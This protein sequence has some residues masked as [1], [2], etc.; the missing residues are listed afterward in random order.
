MLVAGASVIAILGTL[1]KQASVGTASDSLLLSMGTGPL[2]ATEPD[3]VVV[4]PFNISLA[5]GG[6][7]LAARCTLAPISPL[8][9][10]YTSMFPTDA[11]TKSEIVAPTCTSEDSRLD[12]PYRLA[13]SP[14]AISQSLHTLDARNDVIG[15]NYTLSVPGLPM[16]SSADGTRND[17]SRITLTVPAGQTGS[18]ATGRCSQTMR[19]TL[20]VIY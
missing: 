3:N 4:V 16:I 1:E 10:T 19:H 13:F 15:L 7:Y 12:A 2:G 6:A 17:K 11:V 20:Y 9:L 14:T 8:T 18:C 5:R